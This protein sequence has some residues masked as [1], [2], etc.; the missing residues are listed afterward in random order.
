MQLESY[1][2]QMRVAETRVMLWEQKEVNEF[3]N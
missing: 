3:G 2:E 1:C